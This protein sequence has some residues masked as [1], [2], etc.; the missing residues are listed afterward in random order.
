MTGSDK[1]LEIIQGTAQEIGISMIETR[2]E[3]EIGDK[4]PVL[5]Q[6]IETGTV[7]PEQNQGLDLAPM[8]APIGTDLD[9]TDA[10]SMTISLGNAITL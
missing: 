2:A 5:F 1:G 10:V 7:D 4:G 8:L 3:V 9:A 6:G